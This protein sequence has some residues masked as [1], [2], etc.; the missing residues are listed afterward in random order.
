MFELPNTALARLIRL[1]HHRVFLSSSISYPQLCLPAILLS[2]ASDGPNRGLEIRSLKTR[3][4]LER[5]DV[6]CTVGATV[7]VSQR[8]PQLT[9]WHPLKCHEK[10]C[11]L[12]NMARVLC[13]EYPKDDAIPKVGAGG[14][15]Q[16]DLLHGIVCDENAVRLLGALWVRSVCEGS[17]GCDIVS[18]ESGT[19]VDMDLRSG[20]REKSHHEDGED[21]EEVHAG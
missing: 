20:R 10:V 12:V 7:H 18:G 3:A 17:G 5:L 11:L 15:V 21:V 9:H 6:T 8:C 14:V 16:L 13:H 4:V 19:L 1:L 2:L